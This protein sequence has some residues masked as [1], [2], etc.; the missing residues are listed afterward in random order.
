MINKTNIKY[1]SVRLTLC[2]LIFLVYVR[3]KFCLSMSKRKPL[4]Q[5]GLRNLTVYR[6]IL[7]FNFKDLVTM[8]WNAGYAFMRPAGFVWISL[9]LRW[10]EK[11]AGEPLESIDMLNVAS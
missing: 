6:R 10:E 7:R 2:T 9:A 11:S 4:K 1:P 5:H 3:T 8:I